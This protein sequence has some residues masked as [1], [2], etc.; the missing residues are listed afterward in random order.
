MSATL[1]QSW[2]PSLD[3]R[4]GVRLRLFWFS[5]A[6]SGISHLY[7]WVPRMPPDV[8]ICPVRPPGREA[9]LSERPFDRLEP[10]IDALTS[11]VEQA[12]DRPYVLV[13]HSFGALVAFELARALK[14]RG[15]PPP[16][17]LVVSGHASPQIPWAYPPIRQVPDDEFI[18]AFKHR[19]NS[20]IE[21]TFADRDVRDLFLPILRADYSAVETYRFRDDGLLDC[22]IVASG[23]LE[24]SSSNR[25]S[26]ERWRELTRGDFELRMFPGGHFFV[27]EPASGYIDDLAQRIERLLAQPTPRA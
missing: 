14:R 11:A 21:E 18:Q 10:L 25:A 23:G 20:D 6:G 12:L 13:G 26:L 8:N 15:A 27:N 1:V 16:R 22:P 5:H 3:R 24:D 7:R 4:P 19:Y 17:L 2:L 9:R